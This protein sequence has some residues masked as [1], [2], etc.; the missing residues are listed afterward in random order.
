L[1]TP[2]PPNSQIHD[3]DAGDENFGFRGLLGVGRRFLVDGAQV[4]SLDRA[5][6]VDRLADHVDDAAERAGAD[7]NADRLAGVGDFLASDQTFGRVHRDGAHRTLAEM[8]GDLEH[9]AVAGVLGLQRIEN[10]R[11][12][13]LELHVDDGAHHLRHAANLIGGGGGGYFGGCLSHLISLL[14]SEIVVCA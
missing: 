2:A 9:Q 6:F 10:C 5:C 14:R 3:L 13:T 4:V 8:L 7:R 12:L 11:Q 1:P